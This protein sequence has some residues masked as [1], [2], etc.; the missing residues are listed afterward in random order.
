MA[1]ISSVVSLVMVMATVCNAET[2][3]A[4]FSRQIAEIERVSGGRL[5]VAVIDTGSERRFTYRGDERFAL[6]STFKVLLVCA[7]LSQI[8]EGREELARVVT[9]GRSD[10]LPYSPVSEKNAEKGASTVEDLCASAIEESDNTAA[11]LLLRIVG[12]PPGLTRYIREQGDPVT[13]LD[14][15]EPALNSNLPGDLR[16]TTTP[17]AM[18]MTLARLLCSNTLSRTSRERLEHWL[19]GCRTGAHR[20]RGG[21]HDAVRIGDKTGS[22]D[23]GAANDVAIVW[24]AHSAPYLVAVYYTDSSESPAERDK[25]IARVGSAVEQSLKR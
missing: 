21:I 14:R 16:D 18:A 1:Y 3:D 12:G 23:R 5:G 25:A 9:F 17:S 20:L 2:A 24:P 8:D 19:T 15:V 22:G 11:N 4:A 7:V 13:R 10:L 6:C